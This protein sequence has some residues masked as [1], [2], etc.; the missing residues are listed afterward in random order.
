MS[1][2]NATN[3]LN[4]KVE[5]RD[6][7]MERIFDAPRELVFNAFSE[8]EHLKNWWG[9]TGWETTNR[10]FEFKSGG[11]WHYCMRCI[12]ENQGDFYG[13]EIWGK[14]FFHEIVAPEKIVYTD[15]F[16]DEEGNTPDS[17]PGHLVTMT[18]VAHD[19]KTKLTMRYQ[20]SSLETPQQVMD[21]GFIQGLG[22]SFDRLEDFLK[23][24]RS[25]R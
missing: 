14:S 16:S 5:G 8:A 17:T 21:S 6:L 10:T 7:I 24:K 15:T 22:S 25:I 9:P 23:E 4:T 19:E 2:N 13:Q 20:L 12:D 1:E 11:V 18:F 3:E